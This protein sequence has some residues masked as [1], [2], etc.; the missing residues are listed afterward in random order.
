MK[1]LSYK[2]KDGKIQQIGVLNI[3]SPTVSQTLGQ[4]EKEVVSQKAITDKF[5]SVESKLNNID[6]KTKNDWNATSTQDGYIAN[7]PAILGGFIF[8]NSGENSTEILVSELYNN[9][10]E[11]VA[12]DGLYVRRQGNY[13][14][15]IASTIKGLDSLHVTGGLSLVDSTG[16]AKYLSIDL[17]TTLFKV[18]SGTSLPNEPEENDK[19]KIHLLKLSSSENNNSYAEYIWVNVGTDAIPN[20]K[21]EKLGEATLDL[22][23]YA[24][25]DRVEAIEKWKNDAVVLLPNYGNG[26]TTVFANK[27]RVQLGLA[28]YNIGTKIW[29]SSG[30]SVAHVN[31]PSATL[32]RAGVMSAQDKQDLDDIKPVTMDV[33]IG[34]GKDYSIQILNDDLEDSIENIYEN[35]NRILYNPSLLTFKFVVI[36]STLEEDEN[37]DSLFGNV[38]DPIAAVAET[39]TIS[40]E[41]AKFYTSIGNKNLIITLT[42]ESI[43]AEF[44]KKSIG[45][46]ESVWEDGA[47]ENS[48]QINGSNASGQYSVAEGQNT[49]SLGL[50]SHSEGMFTSALGPGS[51]AEGL[52][53]EAQG[54]FSHTEGEATIASGN[55]SHAEGY[56]S[57]AQGEYSH[58]EGKQTRTINKYEHASGYFNLSLN[59]SEIITWGDEDVKKYPGTDIENVGDGEDEDA[60]DPENAPFGT[61]YNTLFTVGNGFNDDFG[62]STQADGLVDEAPERESVRHNAFEVRQSGDIYI[63]DTSAE[64]EYYEKPMIHL[65]SAL[66]NINIISVDMSTESGMFSRNIPVIYT[67]KINKK[68]GDEGTLLCIVPTGVPIIR[69]EEE[70]LKYSTGYIC[71]YDEETGALYNNW[72][73]CESYFTYENQLDDE[74]NPTPNEI[75]ICGYK[76]GA[77]YKVKDTCELYYGNYKGI[78]KTVQDTFTPTMIGDILKCAEDYKRNTGVNT[79]IISSSNQPLPV[80]KRTCFVKSGVYSFTLTLEKELEIGQEL[81][82]FVYAGTNAQMIIPAMLFSG[83]RVITYSDTIIELKENILIE[84]NIIRITNE[85]YVISP[86]ISSNTIPPIA[87]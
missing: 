58:T 51:H 1:T 39:V 3:T 45:T 33:L 19:N 7:K 62:V 31:F 40:G 43:K 44:D 8:T 78:Y 29:N 14:V 9:K 4:S 67:T 53:T 70:D 24:K 56:N 81:H 79:I 2:D 77:Y 63:A 49:N 37:G 16:G 69:N 11:I 15:Y 80:D 13:G 46:T 50:G 76:I 64:G 28:P 59:K 47:G 18:V 30:T 60:L 12:A 87:H 55:W 22:S 71:L 75:Y 23:G 20:W 41:T 72:L 82:I 25:A 85:E 21:W 26:E 86:V 32:E 42:P 73:D 83:S 5:N 68:Y 52:G 65:Q 34:L 38:M 36:Q 17:D 35:L 10:F 6:N 57:E 27:D 66:K 84:F 54:E 74:L 48:V 61:E